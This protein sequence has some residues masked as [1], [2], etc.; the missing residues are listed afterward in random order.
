[1]TKNL[2]FRVEAADEDVTVTLLGTA[3]MVKYRKADNQTGLKLFHTRG[4]AS[5]PRPALSCSCL[6]AR[7][8]KSARVRMGRLDPTP[9]QI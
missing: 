3:L 4:D 8:C 9:N 1:M 6:A 5:N 7:Q 2:E